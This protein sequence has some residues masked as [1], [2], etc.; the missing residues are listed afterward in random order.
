MMHASLVHT[1]HTA[2]LPSTAHAMRG[3]GRDLRVRGAPGGPV[4]RC[5]AGHLCAGHEAG[6]PL[7]VPWTRPPAAPDLPAP[8]AS[9]GAEQDRAAAV[10]P[11]TEAATEP[12]PPQPSKPGAAARNGADAGAADAAAAKVSTAE[13]VAQEVGFRARSLFMQLSDCGALPRV[14]LQRTATPIVPVPA[15]GTRGGRW[16]KMPPPSKPAAP[17]KAPVMGHG[18]RRRRLFRLCRCATIRPAAH[19]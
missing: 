11:A 6:A 5:S 10:S 15:P 18:V 7:Q 8:D 2:Q 1:D 12:L 9:G 4:L 14:P 13:E 3:W 16:P 17:E 19:A